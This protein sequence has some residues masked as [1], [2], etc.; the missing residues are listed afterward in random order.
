MVNGVVTS[1]MTLRSQLIALGH[2]VKVLTLSDDMQSHITDDVVYIG[3]VDAKAIYPDVRIKRP[4]SRAC[5]GG[6]IKWRPDVIH[7]NTEFS[8]FFLARPISRACHCPMVLTYHTNYEDY[9]HYVKLDMRF[10]ARLLKMYLRHISKYMTRI[11]SP[12]EKTASQL[13]GYG[14]RAPVRVIP[15][16]LEL[17]SLTAPAEPSVL[18]GIRQKHG[19]MEDVTTFI[20][21]GRL[22]R[23]KNIEEVVDQLSDCT[24]DDFQ[25]VIVG[26][27]PDRESIERH[28]RGSRIASRIIFTGMVPHSHIAPYY[29]LADAFISASTSETQGLTY[30]EAMAAGLTLLCRSDKCL[31]GVV[32]EGVNGFT[33]SDSSQFRERLGI[34]LSSP[35][36]RKE[37]GARA[38]QTA[39]AKFGA[40]QFAEDVARL[41]EEAIRDFRPYSSWILSPLWHKIMDRFPFV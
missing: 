40:R 24:R 30:I 4:V 17:E 14:V 20:F 39:L 34:L 11:I 37:M 33:F 15:T 25:F 8:T 1:V 29:K 21:V 27:G 7:C 28:A 13:V 36:L 22:G 16:G 9:L 3:S 41:Y 31:E 6:I 35:A 23:E 10:G 5:I 26:D 2:E 12:T 32:E 19:I 38:Q 18:A